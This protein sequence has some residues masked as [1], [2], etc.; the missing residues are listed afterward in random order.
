M[1]G[2][3]KRLKGAAK[4]DAMPDPA[5]VQRAAMRSALRGDGNS[6]I[7]AYGGD[8]CPEPA[9]KV[10]GRVIGELNRRNGHN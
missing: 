1:L 7:D 3:F 8:Y 10:W 6:K 4:A 2:I 9:S 5:T